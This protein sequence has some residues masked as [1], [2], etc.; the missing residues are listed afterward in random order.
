M[1]LKEMQAKN[2]VL[3]AKPYKLADGDGLF[4]LVKPNGSKLWR[5]KYRFAGKEKLLSFGAYPEVSLAGAREQRLCAKH[6]LAQGQDPMASVVRTSSTDAK[7]FER[8]A[9][10]WHKNR[11]ESLDP[12]HAAR[13]W[14]RL[15]RDVL[16]VLG[17]M[18][19]AAITAP[20]VLAMIRKI[21][22]RG[23]LDISRRAKQ[24]VGQVFQFAIAS[25]WAQSD[26]TTHLRGALKPKPRVQHMGRIPTA[27]LPH[28]LAKLER[29]K[30]D[31]PRRSAVTRNALQFA[32]L[33]WV[34]TKELRFATRSEFEGLGSQNPIW[35]IPAERMKMKREHIVPLSQQAKTIVSE[36][37]AAGNEP[38]VFPGAKPLQPLSENTMIYALYRMGYIGRQT[39]HGFRSVA[40]TWANELD[41]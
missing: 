4:L 26:P 38:Y 2:A 27:D 3:K 28:F 34:R 1:P 32:L 29:Y 13:V 36:M 10:H 19:I 35:R 33:T 24:C 39:V 15:E 25:G 14:S 11:E 16:P 21:E 8:I 22:E 20:D 30:E 17:M 18:D 9:K 23:A 7:S 12:A 37:L 31:N 5:M 6:T 40:S 41:L